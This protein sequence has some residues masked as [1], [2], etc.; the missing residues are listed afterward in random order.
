LVSGTF[1]PPDEIPPQIVQEKCVQPTPVFMASVIPVAATNP[2]K[3]RIEMVGA[4]TEI[5]LVRGDKVAMRVEC[6][7][8]TAQMPS[9]GLEAIG[10]VTVATSGITVRCN[11]VMIGWQTGEITMDGQVRI[12]YFDGHH[13]SEMAT[14][15]VCWRLNG[16]GTAVGITPQPAPIQQTSS[17]Q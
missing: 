17:H 7:R 12:T 9:G 6:E 5:E 2:Y 15:S 8:V 10:K 16:I 14:E 4:T 13:Q 3:V 11:R 1:T